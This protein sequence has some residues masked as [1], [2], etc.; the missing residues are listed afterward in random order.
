M[1]GRVPLLQIGRFRPENLGQNALAMIRNLF[2]G[3]FVFW[4]LVFTFIAATYHPRGPLYR[5]STKITITSTSNATFESDKPGSL[6]PVVESEAASFI[7]GR[8]LVY[9]GGGDRCQSMD[10]YLWS[11]MCALGEARY[12]N[13][14]L[15]MDLSICLSSIYTSSHQD[16]ERKDFRFYFDF[17]YLKESAYVLDSSQFAFD[18]NRWNQKNGLKSHLVEDVGITPM[19]LTEVEDTLVMR[20]FRLDTY[21]Y[22]VCEGKAESIVQ[23]PWHLVR[24]SKLL[25]GIASAIV[26]R[27]D[28]DFDSIL[29]KRREKATNEE[30]QTNLDTDTSPKA[31]LLNLMENIF[32]GGRNLYVATNE[33][34]ASFFDPLKE[35][36][37]T[38]FLDEYKDL[39][40]EKSEWY[41]ETR[42]LNNG[43]PV[44]F[45]GYMKTVVDTAVFLKGK[46][47]IHSTD[48]IHFFEQQ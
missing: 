23:R 33:P 11:F 39:W 36:Y 19:M 20:K 15:V 16:E 12:L 45:D 42:K 2:F 44:E 8:Y 7:H 3:V 29:I 28:G 21:W 31:H 48:G 37:T 38:H 9:N 26:S 17:D 24:R 27:L 41:N 13:R 25:M 18:W 46:K 14:T 35:Q 43:V 47:H 4:V 34:D 1:S 32:E 10:H 5:P 40:D 22:R 6:P 30:L